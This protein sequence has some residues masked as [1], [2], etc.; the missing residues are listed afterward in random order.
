MNALPAIPPI[1]NRPVT[2][3]SR[4]AWEEQYQLGAFLAGPFDERDPQLPKRVAAEYGEPSNVENVATFLHN[5]CVQCEDCR[6]FWLVDEDTA[7]SDIYASEGMFCEDCGEGME[8]EPTYAHQNRRAGGYR[9][10]L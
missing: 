5:E 8:V 4:E 7:P 1:S 3:L 6:M 10:S 2:P 9:V